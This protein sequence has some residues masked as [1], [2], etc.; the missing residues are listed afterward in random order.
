MKGLLDQIA[1]LEWVHDNI[2]AFG[3]NPDNIT[4]A[5]F[6]AGGMSIG[7]LL[8][9]PLA[10]GKFHKTINRSGSTNTVAPLDSAVGI[11]EQFL[12]IT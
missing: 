8:S 6:S 4:V 5:G 9:M 2:A 12:K 10:R 11:S 3:G 1:A 7:D